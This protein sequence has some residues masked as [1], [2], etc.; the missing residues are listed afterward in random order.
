MLSSAIQVTGKIWG[1][2]WPELGVGRSTCP[3]MT[4]GSSIWQALCISW[5]SESS[6]LLSHHTLTAALWSACYYHPHYRG[7]NG[8]DAVTRGWKTGP[9]SKS[10]M[11]KPAFEPRSWEARAQVLHGHPGPPLQHPLTK[12]QPFIQ[13]KC[14][15]ASLVPRA[16]TQYLSLQSISFVILFDLGQITQL[17]S[18]SSSIK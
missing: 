3:I 5:W 12:D 10:Y 15:R 4:G 7:G 14:S 18:S 13:H 6:V 16:Q 2:G 9:R 8:T 1:I 17:F 11:L